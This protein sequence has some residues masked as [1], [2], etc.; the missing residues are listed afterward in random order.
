MQQLIQDPHFKVTLDLAASSPA[1]DQATWDFQHVTVTE[2]GFDAYNL[3]DNPADAVIRHQL[4][5]KHFSVL[6]A[7]YAVLYFEGFPHSTVM[8]WVRH[9]GMK[10]LVQS[11][12][13]T[14]QRFLK[15]ASGGLRTEEVFYF[16][17][18]GN[19]ADR[20]GNK[21]E[22]TGRALAEDIRDC[23]RACQKYAYR[24]EQGYSEE[25]ARDVIPQNF[26][27]NF[28]IA[29]TIRG[30]MHVLDQRT[31]A[32]SQLEAQTAAWMALDVLKGWEPTLFG[33]YEEKRAGKNMLAP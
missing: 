5:V 17:P 7:A 10:P 14:G 32:D 20:Q 26:R 30:W 29:G 21:Y 27:Q 2:S 4:G 18:L 8:Q 15:V 12:R 1:P 6:E 11:S 31:L 24:I 9:Q 33:W 25:H 28:A 13:Y 23:D 19:Y 3:P 22:Y 16:R